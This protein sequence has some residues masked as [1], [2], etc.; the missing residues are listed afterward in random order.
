MRMTAIRIEF[1]SVN[2][3]MQIRLYVIATSTHSGEQTIEPRQIQFFFNNGTNIIMQ[4]NSYKYRPEVKANEYK[5][6]LSNNAISLKTENVTRMVIIDDGRKRE[7]T[8]KS[9]RVFARQ[10]DCV[11]NEI[12]NLAKGY[13]NNVV[14]VIE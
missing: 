6:I 5:Y 14:K 13:M 4:S 2:S 1:E 3:D 12:D 11:Y 9:P 10:I 8:L 7:I